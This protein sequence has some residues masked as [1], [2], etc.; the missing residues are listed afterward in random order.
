MVNRDLNDMIT[1]DFRAVKVTPAT[2]AESLD[3][4]TSSRP[5]WGG[6]VRETLDGDRLAGRAVTVLSG[7]LPIQPPNSH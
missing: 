4:T 5:A 2:L 7:T 6:V 1:M 3:K